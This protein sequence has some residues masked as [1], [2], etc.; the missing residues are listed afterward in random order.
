MQVLDRNPISHPCTDGWGWVSQPAEACPVSRHTSVWWK[1]AFAGQ[2]LSTP[3]LKPETKGELGGNLLEGR[4]GFL[5]EDEI[6]WRG[7]L[8]HTHTHTLMQWKNHGKKKVFWKRHT[9]CYLKRIMNMSL[10]VSESEF[11]CLVCDGNF[12]R[13]DNLVPVWWPGIM[14]VMHDCFCLC[15]CVSYSICL[16]IQWHQLILSSFFF[17]WKDVSCTKHHLKYKP[18]N[19]I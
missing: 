4:G 18:F 11:Q 13:D 7:S 10:P 19:Q 17:Y 12:H 1:V 14:Q 15:F 8:S 5:S 3:C 16:A 9:G 2:K 6:I